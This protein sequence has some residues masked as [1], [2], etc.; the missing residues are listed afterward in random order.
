MKPQCRRS[1]TAGMAS[2]MRS[3]EVRCWLTA[4]TGTQACFPSA[5]QQSLTS[6][7][8]SSL[9]RRAISRTHSVVRRLHPLQR[10]SAHSTMLGQSR[11]CRQRVA[12]TACRSVRGGGGSGVRVSRARRL[13]LRFGRLLSADPA[14][15][16]GLQAPQLRGQVRAARGS[17]FGRCQHPPEQADR[18]AFPSNSEKREGALGR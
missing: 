14:A 6:T 18:R 17:A 7:T 13:K 1:P 4:A 9:M 3:C 5:S 10:P 11:A 16:Q 15:P 12:A 8:N 2:R